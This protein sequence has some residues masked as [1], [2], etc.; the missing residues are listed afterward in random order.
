MAGVGSK[1]GEHRGGRK[2]GVPNRFTT[3]VRHMIL[4]ALTGAGGVS[5]L[6]A[7]AT[8]NPA[9]FMTLLGKTLPKDVN[10]QAAGGLALS[11]HLSNGAAPK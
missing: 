8:A 9:A 1:P 4:R 7:Q 10:V 5:Y 11:I 2:K 6:Q 3:D